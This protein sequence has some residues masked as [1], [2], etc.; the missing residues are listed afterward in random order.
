MMAAKKSWEDRFEA[1]V[2]EFPSI[3][4]F[5]WAQ[6]I[7]RDTEL[8]TTL[9][10]DVIKATGDSSRPG[11]RPPLSRNE[12]IEK[13]NQVAA[14]DFTEY[15]FCDAFRGLC[16]GKSVR[17]VAA[18]TG[19]DRNMVHGLM[20]GSRTPSFQSM[21]IIAAAFSKDPSFFLEYRVGYILSIVSKFLYDSPETASLWF[22]KFKVDKIEVK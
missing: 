1:M 8:F 16:A 3:E 15:E 20:T 6:A 4:N 17:G 2:K 7:Y 12:A 13:L 5:N 18:K 22:E 14:E 10:G 11:K 9:L 21:E 19:L